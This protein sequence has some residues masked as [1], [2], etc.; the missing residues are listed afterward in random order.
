MF[1]RT[2]LELNDLLLLM[3]AGCSLFPPPFL[4]F[5]SSFFSLF[6]LICQVLNM[7]VCK[8]N[9]RQREPFCFLLEFWIDI[10]NLQ[11]V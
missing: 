11:Q 10:L 6:V 8:T 3:L 9:T 5:S 1:Y 4:D 2:E 7:K